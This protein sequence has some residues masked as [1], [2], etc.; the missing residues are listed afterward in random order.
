LIEIY[1]LRKK[2]KKRKEKKNENWLCDPKQYTA[3]ST[4]QSDL[5]EITEN[6][7]KV[8]L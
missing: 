4:I 8:Y 2:E 1:F 3:L 7:N 6:G 5:S